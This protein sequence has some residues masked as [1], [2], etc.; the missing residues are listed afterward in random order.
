VFRPGVSSSQKDVCEDFVAA[1]SRDKIKTS[2]IQEFSQ[3][4]IKMRHRTSNDGHSV[5]TTQLWES[6][7]NCG[8]VAPISP[9]E[10]AATLSPKDYYNTS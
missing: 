3:W 6:H 4:V 9:I 10:I 7:L 2:F 1:L 5:F 8:M